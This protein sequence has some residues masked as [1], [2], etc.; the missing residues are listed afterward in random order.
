MGSTTF[1]GP[2]KAGSE[3][4]DNIGYVKMVQSSAVTQAAS[5][6]TITIPAGSHI[7][8]AKLFVTTVWNGAATTMGLGYD[9]DADAL[10]TAT[11]IEGDTLGLVDISPT[12]SAAV[13]GRWVDV[14]SSDRTLALT[15]GNTGTGVGVLTIEY[16]Q[17]IDLS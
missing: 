1:S 17:A 16:I 5:T 2:I 4:N 6:T 12:A 9:D 14:G 15:S 13:T 3:R 8:S 7:V 10:T 11:A